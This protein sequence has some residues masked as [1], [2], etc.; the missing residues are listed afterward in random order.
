MISVYVII[1][2]VIS[3]FLKFETEKALIDDLY[4]LNGQVPM[5]MQPD[6]RYVPEQ[7]TR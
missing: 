6:R 7:Q 4:I 1:S 5:I 2:F 3:I